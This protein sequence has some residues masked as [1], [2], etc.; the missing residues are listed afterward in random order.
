MNIR[1]QIA[2]V[3]LGC[4]A[5]PGSW[6]RDTQTVP[7][8]RLNE[9]ALAV[10][11]EH[12][13]MQFDLAQIALSELAAVYENEAMR[14]R[15][16][17]RAKKPGLWRWAAAVQNLATDYRIL[18]ESITMTTSIEISIGPENSLFLTIDKRLVAISSPRMNEQAAFEQNIITQFCALNRCEDLLA[19]PVAVAAAPVID[20]RGGNTR[21]SFSQNSGPVCASTDGL[22]FQFNSMENL[23]RK[24]QVC[25]RTVTELDALATAI[26]GEVADGAR[27]D[28]NRLAIHS[29]ADGDEQVTINGVG[30]YVRLP[31][32]VLAERGELL[33]LVRPWLAA[34]VRGAPYT[35]VVLHAGR[36]LGPPGYPLE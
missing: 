18:A 36:L 1:L 34:K 3:L 20:H 27:V 35:F 9:L 8:S 32:P 33:E 5:L 15:Q 23:G 6:A 21:W 12:V 13:V 16:D 11:D 4:L 26:A 14:A 30:H 28:W 25:T 19:V 2:L 29:L 24:R 22:Q 7:V 10:L 31:L 17:A